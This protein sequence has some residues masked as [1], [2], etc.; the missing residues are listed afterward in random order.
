MFS[1]LHIASS[2]YPIYAEVLY[3]FT[4]AGPQEL[5]LEKG[6][7]IEIL[8][9]EIGPWWFGR[10]KKED[11]SLVEEILDPEL[12]WF[13]KEFVRVIHSPEVDGFF[14]RYMAE[15]EQR[16][17]EQ[18]QKELMVVNH[19]QINEPSSA[20]A[21]PQSS[22]SPVNDSQIQ[23]NTSSSA[24]CTPV[25]TSSEDNCNSTI[26][27]KHNV[28]TIVIESSSPSSSLDH[29]HHHNVNDDEC[30]A[31]DDDT[32]QQHQ[33]VGCCSSSSMSTA[34]TANGQT[35]LSTSQSLNVIMG[36]TD[37]LRR[38]AVKELLDTEVNYVK[39]LQAICEG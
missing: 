28:T 10:I 24:P 5:G 27:D 8:R 29:H 30:N 38:S 15:E 14:L 21:P 12:G 33:D 31:E 19:M 3:N 4:A 2:Y 1:S 26:I 32:M 11:A 23:L 34:L 36:S 18:Q 16:H 7:L 37:M 6:T 13:P 20:P 25:N 22:S 17:K 35:I 39:L 9:K